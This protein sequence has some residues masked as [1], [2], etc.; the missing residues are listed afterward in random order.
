MNAQANFWTASHL[1]P[2]QLKIEWIAFLAN[3]ATE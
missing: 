1:Q 2:T 3:K